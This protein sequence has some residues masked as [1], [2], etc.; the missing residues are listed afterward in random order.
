M[1]YGEQEWKVRLF[2]NKEN[3]AGY[4]TIKTLYRDPQNPDFGIDN[5]L[6]DKGH[7]N[8]NDRGTL[9]YKI[10]IINANNGHR[11][12]RETMSDSAG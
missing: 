5:D 6:C 10:D 8:W 4:V 11:V 9:T 3:D 7:Y 2:D 12:L 1:K